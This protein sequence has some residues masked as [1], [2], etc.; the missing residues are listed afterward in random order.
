MQMKIKMTILIRRSKEIYLRCVKL[1]FLFAPIKCSFWASQFSGFWSHLFLHQV[2]RSENQKKFQVHD[3]DDGIK[4][5]QD[6]IFVI[7]ESNTI[8][9]PGALSTK[10]MKKGQ[11]EE[12]IEFFVLIY[13]MI[14]SEDAFTAFFT[15]PTPWGFVFVAFV[16]EFGICF[17]ING[18]FRGYPILWYSS[19]IRIC[20]FKITI[21]NPTYNKSCPSNVQD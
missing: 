14:H 21:Q 15:V 1:V 17:C 11:D 7:L 19:R 18:T 16:A 20:S 4:Q 10:K 13:M 12:E 9:D 2:V 6:E 5:K 8:T 3:S